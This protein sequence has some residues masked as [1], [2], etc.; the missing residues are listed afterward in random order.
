MLPIVDTPTI[1]YVVEEAV[2]AGITDILMIIGKGKR[3]IEEHFDRN[4][5]LEQELEAKARLEEL[6]AM[7]RISSMAEVHFIWQK[8][9]N[10][11]G[12]AVLCARRH[13][14]DEPFL[15]LLGDSLVQSAEPVARRLIDLYEHYSES[16]VL[17]EEVEMEKV[18]RYGVVAAKPMMDDL[19]LVTDLVEKP[20]RE[21]APSNL[22]IAARYVFSHRIFDYLERTPRGKNDEIQLTDAMRLMLK[23]SAMYGL[24]LK[25][26]RHDI[27]NKLDFL[28]TN[29]I[30]GL[31]REDIGPEFREFIA[32]IAR[33]FGG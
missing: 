14:G 19:Y 20:R 15:L 8:R 4:F 24:L 18:E 10:G 13:V 11:L 12:D 30:F 21:E 28:K 7:R 6:A 31:G 27:G 5:E 29:V 25:G 26:R 3:A 17:L 2:A 9:A 1:Q 23:D 32:E 33:G 22:S 16:V